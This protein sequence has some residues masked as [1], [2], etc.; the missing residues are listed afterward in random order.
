MIIL[1]TATSVLFSKGNFNIC[2]FISTGILID[3]TSWIS[4][5]CTSIIEHCIEDI[6]SKE[7]VF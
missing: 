6:G 2:N 3:S 1:S 7:L 5:E 4:L